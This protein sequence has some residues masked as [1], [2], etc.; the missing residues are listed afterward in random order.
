MG[1][2]WLRALILPQAAWVPYGAGIELIALSGFYEEKGAWQPSDHS[3]LGKRTWL[4]WVD[5][6]SSFVCVLFNPSCI[7]SPP[8]SS[9]SPPPCSDDPCKPAPWNGTGGRF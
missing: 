8:N 2:L 1:E 9:T 3:D 4:D 6:D 7:L 5:S